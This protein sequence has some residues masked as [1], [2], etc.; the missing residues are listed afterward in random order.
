MADFITLTSLSQLQTLIADGIGES[1]TL[2]FKASPSLTRDSANVLELCKDV[3][4][5]ANSA[6]G[7]IVYG[8]AEDKKA[9]TSI[10]M[11]GSP[12]PRSPANGSTRFLARRSSLA[13]WLCGLVRLTLVEAAERL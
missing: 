10:S 11:A 1:L 3:S 5:F 6:G 8:I 4:A 2:D 9:K 7:Q 13:C 12:I